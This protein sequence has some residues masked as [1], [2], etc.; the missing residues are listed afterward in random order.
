MSEADATIPEAVAKIPEADANIPEADAKMPEAVVHAASGHPHR[1]EEAVNQSLL[2]SIV[3]V[4]EEQE[5]AG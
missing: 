4:V 2:V 5:E 1:R 3:E